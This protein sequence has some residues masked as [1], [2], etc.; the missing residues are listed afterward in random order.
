MDPHWFQCGSGSQADPDPGFW[1]PPIAKIWTGF[2]NFFSCTIFNTASSAAPQIPLCRRM[3]GSNPGQFRLR[4]WLSDALTTQ[5]D[6]WK[7]AYCMLIR[8]WKFFIPCYASMK[9]VPATGEAFSHH[10]RTSSAS[11]YFFKSHFYLIDPDA[12][13]CLYLI[14]T[15]ST[16]AVFIQY[17][18][19]LSIT[20]SYFFLLCASVHWGR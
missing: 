19:C 1:W 8:N 10:T 20:L 7:K 6:S 18:T 13:H 3:L 9:D 4:H 11:K 14:G 16:H 2:F 5:L 15:R 12:Q 17:C